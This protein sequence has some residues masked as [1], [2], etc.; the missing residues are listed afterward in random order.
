MVAAEAYFHPLLTTLVMAVVVAVRAQLELLRYE[1][2]VVLA[3]P[4]Q[5]RRLQALL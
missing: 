5:H 1:I 3:V 2:L 4:E